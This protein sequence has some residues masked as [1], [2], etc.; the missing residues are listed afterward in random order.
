MRLV[1]GGAGAGT[2]SSAV[3]AA[4]GASSF[5]SVPTPLGVPGRIAAVA[6]CVDLRLL[7]LVAVVVLV[8][9]LVVVLLLLLLSYLVADATVVTGVLGVALLPLLTPVGGR[10]VLPSLEGVEARDSLPTCSIFFAF[11]L[12]DMELEHSLSISCY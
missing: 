3:S 11:A 5:L 2:S 12:P 9:V 1:F 8:L 6:E 4:A 7:R 10:D